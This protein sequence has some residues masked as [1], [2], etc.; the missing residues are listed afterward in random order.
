MPSLRFIKKVHEHDDVY[1][2][3]FSKPKN[4]TYKAG[5][6]GIF[7]LPGLSRPHPLSLTSAPHQ[8]FISFTTKV[9]SGSRFKK[10]LLSLAK[11][12]KVYM[13]GPI[14][15]FTFDS[16]YNSHVFLAQGIGIT[17]FQS[18]LAHAHNS[19]AS[20]TITLVHASR[21]GHTFK[22]VSA[23]L[24][25][26]AHFAANTDEFQSHAALQNTEDMFYISGSPRFIRATKKFLIDMGVK[27]SHIKTDLFLGY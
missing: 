18:M 1:S 5:Q 12:E 25:D 13:F 6:H 19:N 17:P 23:Q 20:D 14:M 10:R 15:N 3:F 4:L 26:V 27:R 24:A 21:T 22:D 16:R 8:D 11:N 2:F 9:S 7:F